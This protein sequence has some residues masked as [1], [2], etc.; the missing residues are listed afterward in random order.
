MPR[1]L[2][3]RRRRWYG[4]M[5]IPE[6]LR[7]Q[8]GKPRFVQSLETESLSVAERRVLP[9]I[10][11]WR[12]LID[13]ARSGNAPLEC[14]AAAFRGEYNKLIAQGV[15]Q[16]EAEE[17]LDDVATNLHF[18]PELGIAANNIAFNK[19]VLLSQH[20]E[21]YFASIRGEEKPKT[22]DGKR[23][24]LRRL[25]K[26]FKY[27]HDVTRR[28]VIDWVENEMMGQCGLSS[29]TCSRIISAARGYWEYLE[30]HKGLVLPSPFVGVV[31]SKKKSKTAGAVIRS[32]RKDFTPIHFNLLL[33]ASSH[34]PVLTDLIRL[35]AYTGCR[36]EELCSLKLDKVEND[37]F[38]VENTKTAAGWR[39]I[40]IHPAIS[41]VVAR[42]RDQSS[43]GYLLSGL[44]FNKYGDRSNAIGKRFGRL[45]KKCGFGEEYVF[46]SLRKG[47]ASQLENAGIPENISARLLGHEFYTMS[48]GVYSGGVSF[49]VL[50]DAVLKLSW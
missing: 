35:G 2:Q 24:D 45:K 27:A 13:L 4:V 15:P 1:Y 11:E 19:W 41:Q 6:A 31:P 37:Y 23:T 10:V 9:L 12:R 5:E 16:W 28:S 38:E 3:K 20:F 46:H 18:N 29:A 43:D 8:F 34:D 47:V 26:K 33:E 14:E 48:Y 39:T 7:S 50:R 21:S 40:P 32:K 17:V 25:S 49:D 36:I 30:R 44:T 22:I 42:L